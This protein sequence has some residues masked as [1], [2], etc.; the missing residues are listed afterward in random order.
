MEGITF[1]I[2]LDSTIMMI[3]QMLK[4]GRVSRPFLGINMVGLSK[5]VWNHLGDRGVNSPPVPVQDGVLL[6]NVLGGS[7]AYKAGLEAFDVVT[8][9]L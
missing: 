6:T 4:Q 9:F 1:A 2:R 8:V 7:P 5:A 3:R